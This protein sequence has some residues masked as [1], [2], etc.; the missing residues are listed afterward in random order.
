M[1]INLECKIKNMFTLYT[2]VLSR[3]LF[4]ESVSVKVWKVEES[5]L[6]NINR[7]IGLLF[8]LE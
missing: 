2:Y 7:A 5:S 3:A 4:T 8:T 6:I 1:K